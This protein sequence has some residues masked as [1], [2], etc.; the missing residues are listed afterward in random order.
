M[1][2]RKRTFSKSDKKEVDKI[3]WDKQGTYQ[4]PNSDHPYLEHSGPSRIA[5]PTFTPLETFSLF[6]G[7]YNNPHYCRNKPILGAVSNQ[8]TR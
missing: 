4:S 8:E 2:S 5:L 7:R 3:T 1:K 6:Y